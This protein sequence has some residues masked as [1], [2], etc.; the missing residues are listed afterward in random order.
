[1][2]GRLF[3]LHESSCYTD[4]LLL[5][6]IHTSVDMNELFKVQNTAGAFYL[7]NRSLVK[8]NINNQIPSTLA[9][10]TYF[11]ISSSAVTPNVLL[12]E[13]LGSQ[14]VGYLSSIGFTIGFE[15]FV[16]VSKIQIALSVFALKKFEL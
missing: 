8:K 13:K 6:A 11:L 4:M 16:F 3:Q 1:M 9:L 5:F 10:Y 12:Y 14:K 15:F 2:S 7:Q